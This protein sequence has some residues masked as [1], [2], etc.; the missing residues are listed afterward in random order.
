MPEKTSYQFGKTKKLS[1]STDLDDADDLVFQVSELARSVEEQAFGAAANVNAITLY[2]KELLASLPDPSNQLSPPQ[3]TFCEAFYSKYNLSEDEQMLFATVIVNN[4]KLNLHDPSM[5][6]TNNS[7][8]K[9]I[10]LKTA[11]DLDISVESFTNLV[12]DDDINTKSDKRPLLGPLVA[13][14][15]LEETFHLTV[16]IGIDRLI[17]EFSE[18]NDDQKILLTL[19]RSAKHP[20]FLKFI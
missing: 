4:S 14:L 16:A 8:K 18:L 19:L 6:E 11:K 3:K 10:S 20:D 5:F 15:D 12:S 1:P 7:E 2:R 17:E 13:S 9:L